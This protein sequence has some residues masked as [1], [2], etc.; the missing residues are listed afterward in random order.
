MKKWKHIVAGIIAAAAVIG[1]AGCGR[2]SGGQSSNVNLEGE[3]PQSLNIFCNIG[4]NLSA[5]GGK[6][7]NDCLTFQLL[8]EKTGCH[9]EW[10]HP[11]SGASQERFNLMI[12]SGTLPD[13]IVYS[14]GT[15]NGGTQ[16]Y[17]DDGVI[18]DLTPYIETCMPNFYKFMN[19][20]PELKKDIVDDNGNIH[21]IPYIR[22][23]KELCVYQGTRIRKDWLEKLN[24]EVPTT[25]DELYEVL[26][27]FKTQDPNGNGEADEVPMDG[28]KFE[29]NG[30]GIGNLLWAFGTTYDFHLKDGEVVYGPMLDEFKDGLEYITKL[31]SE[32]LIDTDYLTDDRAKMD[33]KWTQDT[34]GF[35]F[36][37]QP[38]TYYTSMNDGTREVI[39]IGALKAPDGNNYTFNNEYIRQ[40]SY[41]RFA[42]TSANENV[43]GTLKWLDI[44]YG[45][46]GIVMG[47]YGKEGLSFEYV[48]GE[49]VFGDY[50][51]NN[52]NGKTSAQMFGLTCGV[53]S[54][55]FPM[56]QT[57]DF[58]KQTLQ[59]WGVAAV[60]TWLAD[61]ADTSRI[62]P[63]LSLTVEESEVYTRV[64][65]NV[66]TY[67]LEEVNK[68]IT[69]RAGIEEWDAAV[70]QMKT[71]GIEEVLSVQNAAY[72]RY[73][74][75]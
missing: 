65:S 5:A 64:M 53:Q 55:N 59:P 27:A 2:E 72:Q 45:E 75:R 8:E 16:S 23:D 3:I 17:V 44:L 52:P 14:W 46:E 49:P 73:L 22:R 51:F 24:L 50:I 35:G 13:A 43:A 4:P 19:E 57:W 42:V 70:E 69:G 15:V 67:M 10:D 34:V 74:E 30:Q 39:G 66:E 63:T 31:Y 6:S 32:G 60:E 71:L 18:V 37:Y 48:D 25:A 33:A 54:S 20:H 28:V 7:F 40:V 1:C 9:V 12:A 38:S 62:L 36:G 11:A 41:A 26:K 61:D 29:D 21:T 68:V 47:N 56:I 58:Y